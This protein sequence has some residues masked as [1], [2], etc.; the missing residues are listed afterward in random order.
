M[1][2]YNLSRILF[3][4]TFV[5]LLV[6][7]VFSKREFVLATSQRAAVMIASRQVMSYAFS[8]SFFSS[9]M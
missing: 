6:F 7:C 5:I 3:L 8:L 2:F 4:S 9:P 1:N